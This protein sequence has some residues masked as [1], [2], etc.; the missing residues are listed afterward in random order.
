MIGII[1]MI[2]V[3]DTPGEVFTLANAQTLLTFAEA[4]PYVTSLGM[5]SLARDNGGC[6][7]AIEASASCSGLS[8]AT[9]AFSAIFNEIQ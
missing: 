4:N 6:S 5:W 8:Q 3:N 7:T 2:G 1:P 9:Y